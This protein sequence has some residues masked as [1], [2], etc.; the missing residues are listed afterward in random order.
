MTHI[1]SEQMRAWA[2]ALQEAVQEDLPSTG[3]KGTL[4]PKQLADLLGIDDLALFT[5]SI[6]KVKRG[7]TDKLNRMEMTELAVAFVNLLA[8]DTEQTTKA[9]NAIR[10]VSGKDAEV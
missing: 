6:N 10:R 1:L 9:M 7:D 4:N 8:A 3:L 2:K 5:R